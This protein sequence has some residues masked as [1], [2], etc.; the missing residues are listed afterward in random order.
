[1]DQYTKSGIVGRETTK[2]PAEFGEQM[3]TLVVDSMLKTATPSTT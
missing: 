1:M 2:A 3:F